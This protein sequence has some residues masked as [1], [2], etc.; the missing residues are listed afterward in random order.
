MAES[1]NGADARTPRYLLVGKQVGRELALL[2]TAPSWEQAMEGVY[3]L[4]DGCPE[5]VLLVDTIE[6]RSRLVKNKNT[7]VN[8]AEETG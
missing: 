2:G 5:G 8:K 7:L 6:R 1:S 4:L 3:A